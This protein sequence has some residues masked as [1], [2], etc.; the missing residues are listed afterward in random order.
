MATAVAFTDSKTFSSE[1]VN[2][3][4]EGRNRFVYGRVKRLRLPTVLPV[5]GRVF[6]AAY[7]PGP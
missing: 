4:R 1:V 2:D 3:A 6:D 5:P 7:S